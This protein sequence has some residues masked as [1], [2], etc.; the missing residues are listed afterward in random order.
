M[1]V[2]T[3]GTVASGSTWVFNAVRAL[4]TETNPDAVS[5]S[6]RDAVDLL[7]NVPLG[8]RDVVVK[9]HSLANC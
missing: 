8:C 6:A 3:L 5:L 1:L 4:L 9:S 2:I 7:R